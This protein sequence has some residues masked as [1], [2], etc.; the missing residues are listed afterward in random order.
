[1]DD[2]ERLIVSSDTKAAARYGTT[3]LKG[4]Q[5]P[6]HIS[7][8]LKLLFFICGLSTFA[9]S[10]A[11]LMQTQ[12]YAKCFH[13][14]PTFYAAASSAIFMP[15][16]FIQIIQT[17]FDRYFDR[18]YGTYK[19]AAFRIVLSYVGSLVALLAL[20]LAAKEDDALRDSPMFVYLLLA[21]MGLGISVSFGCLVQISSMFPPE[22]HAFF[23]F[24]TYAPFF[25]FAPVNVGV[26][27]LC[28]K[29]KEPETTGG[30]PIYL[31]ETRWDSV[32]V[33]YIVAVTITMAGMICF[34]GIAKHPIGKQLFSKKDAE[35]QR[36]SAP[37]TPG[38]V[39]ESD[40]ILIN[41]HGTHA[42][43][44]QDMSATSCFHKIWI[45][46][47]SMSV[48][49]ICST[50]IAALYI[51]IPSSHFEDL[52]T[53]LLYDYYIFGSVGIVLTSLRPVRKL[54]TSKVLLILTFIRVAFI[55]LS[56]MCT[57]GLFGR[58]DYVVVGLNSLQMAVGG[59]VFSLSFSYAA[60][61]F[62]TK[63][64]RTLASTIMNVFY[65]IAMA[66]AMGSSFALKHNDD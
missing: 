60:D 46:I 38:A 64:A 58:N 37:T 18:K 62:E 65:Y 32:T 4:V 39:N 11:V 22:L 23:F 50:L 52:S 3:E 53:I 14:G 47:V 40:I 8:T 26:G 56:I 9:R 2:Q 17:K 30:D 6:T 55:P 51:D 19:A 31:W 59:M 16:I 15:G 28:E 44:E 5:K 49:T 35:L 1:M 10:E 66:I 41:E 27:D 54:M 29:V 7:N 24:G 42:Q 21:I 61:K 63:P 12:M 34:F 48:T 25:I 33:Y 36:G 57:Q 43:T 13:L 20:I 45:E